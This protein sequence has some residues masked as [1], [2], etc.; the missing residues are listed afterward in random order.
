[1]AG[2]EREDQE[3]ALLLLLLLLLLLGA[4]ESV[5]RHSQS[6]ALAPNIGATASR[7]GASVED[8]N[9]GVVG[10]DTPLEGKGGRMATG[11]VVVE[12]DAAF[13]VARAAVADW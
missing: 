13:Q 8:T 9:S 5:N 10:E 11:S 4:V 12:E 3:C 1:M 2:K 7:E 6:H